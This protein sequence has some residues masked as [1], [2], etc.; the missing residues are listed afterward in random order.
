MNDLGVCSLFLLFM[1]TILCMGII[2]LGIEQK[3]VL[4]A[5]C[6]NTYQNYKDVITCQASWTK[7]KLDYSKIIIKEQ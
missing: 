4:N 5:V 2:G 7:S 6:I 1:V 3:S